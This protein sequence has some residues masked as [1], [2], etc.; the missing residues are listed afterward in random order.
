VHHRAGP[1]AFTS[2]T[3]IDGSPE[4]D[5]SLVE[6]KQQDDPEPTH[7]GPAPIPSTPN[8]RFTRGTAVHV[9]AVVD[10]GPQPFGVLA[11]DVADRSIVDLDDNGARIESIVALGH[12]LG[13][14][15]DVDPSVAPAPAGDRKELVLVVGLTD[16]FDFM[17]TVDGDREAPTGVTAQTRPRATPAGLT[18]EAAQ[19]ADA[20][21]RP[22]PEAVPPAAFGID[23]ERGVAIIV[24]GTPVVPIAWQ[25]LHA[26]ALP[27]LSELLLFERG[28]G[29]VVTRWIDLQ[30]AP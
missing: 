23:V 24:E 9:D 27:R 4:D 26:G 6:G 11:T 5:A 13:N 18:E 22:A 10:Q 8:D 21:A 14:D 7:P 1:R 25:Q 17:G 29:H 15:A 12:Q 3:P 2:L 16:D 20:T 30:T 19:P 28:A